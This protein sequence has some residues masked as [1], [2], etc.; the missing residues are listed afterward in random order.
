MKAGDK[1]KVRRAP[2]GDWGEGTVFIAS[3]NLRSLLLIGE[4][5]PQPLKGIAIHPQLGKVLALGRDREDDDGHYWELI[6]SEQ[7]EVKCE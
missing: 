7:F 5:L 1:V 4:G 2:D 3:E 6:S